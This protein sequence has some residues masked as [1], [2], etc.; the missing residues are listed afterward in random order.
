[1]LKGD[2]KLDADDLASVDPSESFVKHIK[3][4]G[5]Y[6]QKFDLV[7]YFKAEGDTLTLTIADKPKDY[8]REYIVEGFQKTGMVRTMLYAIKLGLTD[9]ITHLNEKRTRK[10]GKTTE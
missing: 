3:H 5:R 2:K 10:Y 1:M 8:Y 7:V 9:L 6:I 4:L